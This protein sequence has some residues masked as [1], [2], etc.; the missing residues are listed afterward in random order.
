MTSS[1]DAIRFFVPAD[2]DDPQP[3]AA[4]R[5]GAYQPD[6]STWIDTSLEVSSGFYLMTNAETT[7]NVDGETFIY[8]GE[9]MLVKGDKAISISD[10]GE[11]SIRA[12][13]VGFGADCSP[14]TSDGFVSLEANDDVTLQ[15]ATDISI[16]CDS[17]V[18]MVEQHYHASTASSGVDVAQGEIAVNLG[19]VM[20]INPMAD[21]DI[22]T[23]GVEPIAFEHSCALFSISSSGLEMSGSKFEMEN[24]GLRT[25]LVGMFLPFSEAEAEETAV[26]DNNA[27]VS[28]RSRSVALQES[29]ASNDTNLVG[30]R[31]RAMSCNF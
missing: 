15:S 23:I 27:A 28:T 24:H 21:I 14:S 16:K 17:L 13:T 6:E 2:P 19:E 5:L 7:T 1:S 20:Y 8:A 10:A 26:S 12:Q 18:Y 4:M 29:G 25:F 3:L 9:G 31:S 22:A 11:T 30:A